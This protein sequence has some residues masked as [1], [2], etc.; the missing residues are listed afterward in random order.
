MVFSFNAIPIG[1]KSILYEDVDL[2]FYL[3]NFLLLK[4]LRMNYHVDLRYFD[5]CN[6]VLSCGLQFQ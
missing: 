1:G 4:T 2:E 3:N 5:Q 6:N